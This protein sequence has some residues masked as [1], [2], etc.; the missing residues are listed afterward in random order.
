MPCNLL[1]HVAITGLTLTHFVFNDGVNLEN[2]ALG[3]YQ[4]GLERFVGQSCKDS[5][6]C[7]QQGV[8]TQFLLIRIII[9]LVIM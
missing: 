5:G 9:P 4:D 6:H 7:R 2:K 3:S 1:G 8:L